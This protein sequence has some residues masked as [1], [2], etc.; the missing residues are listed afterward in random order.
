MK[1]TLLLLL[2]LNSCHT[3]NT[4]TIVESPKGGDFS[5]QST[6]GVFKSENQRGKTLLLFFGFT[7]C[8]H[9]CPLTLSN[10]NRMIKFLSPL[11]QKKISALF[12]SVDPERDSIDVLKNRITPYHEAIN[13]GTDTKENLDKLIKQFGGT[14][15][16]IKGKD[17]T[18]IIVDHTS[19]IFVINSKGVWVDSLKFDSTPDEL[20]AA[21][22]NA[23]TSSPIYAE[24]RQNRQIE[25]LGE[26][27]D[28]DLSKSS[29]E[30]E[31]FKVSFRPYP[32]IAEKNYTIE[33]N[34]LSSKLEPIEIDLEGIDV[35]MGY[36]RPKLKKSPTGDYM[37]TFYI[38]VCE[39]PE[40]NWKARLLVKAEDGLKKQLVFN[41]KT[42]LPSEVS[43]KPLAKP[44]PFS[45]YPYP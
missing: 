7:H 29:C 15:K 23:D 26:N 42:S 36:I 44:E 40:M 27:K 11:E 14:Y 13:A 31:G 30:L 10:I 24:H 38:P 41:F 34:N 2:I 8:P 19:F 33:V 32:I 45:V 25:E 22:K 37:G 35:N 18:D 20:L 28:C 3:K 17:P 43:P 9:I 16:I 21:V 5:I 6:R 1:K 4:S 39:L 12:V